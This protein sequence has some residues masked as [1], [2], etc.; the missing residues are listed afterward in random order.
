MN[1]LL[2]RDVT[3]RRRKQNSYCA[4]IPNMQKTL[5]SKNCSCTEDDWECDY[6]FERSAT[7]ACAKV[8][9]P[10]YPPPWCETGQQYYKSKGYRK[11]AGNSC[12]GGVEHMGDGPFKCPDKGGVSLKSNKGWIAAAV[13]VPFVILVLIAAFFAMRSERLRDKVPVLKALH[14]WRVGYFKMENSPQDDIAEHEEELAFS[15]LDEEADADTEHF[16]NDHHSDSKGSQAVE[17]LHSQPKIAT[18]T[19]HE[20]PFDPRK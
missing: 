9:D 6:G 14:D 15:N 17:L 16:V 8:L 11:V 3:Y 12:Q 7:G 4:N 13:I 1:C 18:P 2:G 19:S 10:T 5:D 20:D